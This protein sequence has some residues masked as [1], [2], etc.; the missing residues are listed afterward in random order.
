MTNAYAE[1]N[2]SERVVSLLSEREQARAQWDAQKLDYHQQLSAI[3][4][5]DLN[6]DSNPAYVDAF[7][8]F[9]TAV[10][11][12]RLY[13]DNIA[14]L[15]SISPDLTQVNG[16]AVLFKDPVV[17]NPAFESIVQRSYDNAIQ[18]Y[19]GSRKKPRPRRREAPARAPVVRNA[20]TTPPL[21]HGDTPDGPTELTPGEDLPVP[22]AG[23]GGSGGEDAGGGGSG[24]G[25]SGGSGG[26]SPSPMPNPHTPWYQSAITWGITAAASVIVGGA[27]W[28][29][30]I[31]RDADYANQSKSHQQQVATLDS[32]K[33]TLNSRVSA[34]DSEKNT[35]AAERDGLRVQRDELLNIY[36]RVDELSDKIASAQ[37][38]DQ[39]ARAVEGVVPGNLPQGNVLLVSMYNFQ[40]AQTAQKAYDQLTAQLQQMQQRNV[41]TPADVD[42]LK[43]T[44]QQWTSWLTGQWASEEF[45][46]NAQA[47]GNTINALQPTSQGVVPQDLESQVRFYVFSGDNANATQAFRNL[48]QTSPYNGIHELVGFATPQFEQKLAEFESKLQ[49]PGMPSYTAFTQRLATLDKKGTGLRAQHYQLQ[50]MW[51]DF[52]RTMERAKQDVLSREVLLDEAQRTPEA[53]ITQRF[54]R[55]RIAALYRLMTAAG[56]G[57]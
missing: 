25:G 46:T 15:Q 35:F 37:N 56:M 30:Y 9:W 24:D 57:R 26:G 10:V 28:L 20:G 16:H 43:T 47:L 33:N 45:K 5:R 4:S 8:Q 19:S 27:G 44:Y 50:S 53:Q 6:Y 21:G 38:L 14:A 13:R 34:L 55:L 12:S 17:E 32:E 2:I 7:K 1:L 11:A 22:S 29:A 3:Q 23:G 36:P 52:M 49:G 42:A 54:D 40:F 51:N 31:N 39:L 48:A 41:R 18:Q